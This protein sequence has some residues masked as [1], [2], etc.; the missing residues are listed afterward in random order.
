MKF[1]AVLS[2]TT[3]DK[4]KCKLVSPELGELVFDAY[5]TP[6]QFAD[7]VKKYYEEEFTIEIH[8]KD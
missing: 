4:M 3:T 6:D 1:K 8:D 7:L 2:R 5:M